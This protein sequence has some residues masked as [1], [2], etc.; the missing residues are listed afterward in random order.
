MSKAE[1]DSDRPPLVVRELII[2]RPSR[3]F[4][5]SLMPWTPVG[6]EWWDMEPLRLPDSEPECVEPSEEPDPCRS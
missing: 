6:S 2:P 1:K 5:A 4:E 3:E